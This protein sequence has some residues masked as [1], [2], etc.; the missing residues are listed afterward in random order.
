MRQI[1]HNLKDSPAYPIPG[2]S[3]HHI[4]KKNLS[5]ISFHQSLKKHFCVCSKQKKLAEKKSFFASLT[6]LDEI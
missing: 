6:C 5:V 3:K 2:I 1:K 4:I